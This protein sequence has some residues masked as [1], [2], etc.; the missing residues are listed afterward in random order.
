MDPEA[1]EALVVDALNSIPEK[2][3][4]AMENWEVC[5]EEWPSPHDLIAAGFSPKDKYALLGLYHG[6]PAT[7]RDSHYMAFP[8]RISIY[9]GPIEAYVGPDEEAI[10]EQ[11]RRT[12]IHEIGHYWGLDDDRIEELGWG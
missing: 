8:D 2:F 5:V 4:E 6:V 1:F 3:L 7:E 9:K 12:V 10:R 11:V